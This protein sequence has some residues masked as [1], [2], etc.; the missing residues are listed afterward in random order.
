MAGK[1]ETITNSASAEAGVE[2]LAELG[3]KKKRKESKK[4]KRKKKKE[5]KRRRRK[6]NKVK[7]R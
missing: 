6:K 4:K 2:A 7:I 3:N 5:E 1:C